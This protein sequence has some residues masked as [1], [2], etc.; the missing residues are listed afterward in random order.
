MSHEWK[1]GAEEGEMCYRLNSLNGKKIL[2]VRNM[3]ELGEALNMGC[4]IVAVLELLFA[5]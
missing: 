5:L 2:T 1:D 3:E 4:A